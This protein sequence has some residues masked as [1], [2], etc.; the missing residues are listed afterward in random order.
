MDI[1]GVQVGQ[2]FY[3]I[4]PTEHRLAA[5]FVHRVWIKAGRPDRLESE[6][7]WKVM[8]SLF[9]IWGAMYPLELLDFKR[10]IAEDRSVERDVH[11][12]LKHEG[13]YIPISYPTRLLQFIKVYFKEEKLQDHKLIL[14][15]IRRYPLLKVTKHK[16]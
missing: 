9:Q 10:V 15:F 2:T 5:E 1:G 4:V 13:G 7:A 16:L 14:K 8:D 11:E 3:D 12:A 6:G